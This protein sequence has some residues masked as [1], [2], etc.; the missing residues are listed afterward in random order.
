[1]GRTPLWETNNKEKRIKAHARHIAALNLRAEGMSY[2]AIAERLGYA[3]KSGAHKAVSRALE[4]TTKEASDAVR[5]YELQRLDKMMSAIWD[6]AM[7]G[8]T[9]SINTILRIMDRRSKL[10][11][12][13]SPQP[14]A[15]NLEVTFINDWRNTNENKN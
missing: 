14:L 10:L 9:K 3:S 5:N 7:S 12:L 8:D 13:D 15:Q 11:G 2:A 4:R 6:K 1:M